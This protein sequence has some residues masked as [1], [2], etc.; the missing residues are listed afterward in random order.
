VVLLAIAVVIGLGLGLTR[1]PAGA[2]SVRPHVEQ[3]PLFAAGALLFAVSALLDGSPAILCRAAALAVLIAVAMANRHLTGMAVIGLGL[4]LNLASLAVNAGVAVRAS[5]LVEAGVVAPG[6]A[7]TA[8]LTG[9]RHLETSADALGV[10]G[11]VL[12]LPLV[13]Q[14]VSFG[15]LIVAFGAADAVRELSRRRVRRGAH[16]EGA[17]YAGV[18]ATTSVNA[19]QV[20]GT[21]P[22]ARPV[23]ATQ[24][25]AKPD[26][27]APATIDLDRET[28]A[29]RAYTDLVASQSR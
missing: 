22:R 18:L 8:D 9:P 6:D 26:A 28:A 21:A 3:L 5:A 7:D 15:D 13:A 17:A 12:P 16:V 29:V 27:E 19:D 20:W 11:E 25:S 10:L 4:L 1:A 2:H 14:V 24:Y 23:S